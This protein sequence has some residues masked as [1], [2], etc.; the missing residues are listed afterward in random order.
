M[1]KGIKHLLDFVCK[2]YANLIGYHRTLLSMLIVEMLNQFKS[3][4]RLEKER[5]NH[6]SD[7]FSLFL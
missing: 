1:K 6:V 3:G 4:C 7:P 2:M 5:M